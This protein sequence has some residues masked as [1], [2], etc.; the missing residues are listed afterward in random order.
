VLPL[1][2]YHCLL[3]RKQMKHCVSQENDRPIAK[4]YICEA[5]LYP[6]PLIISNIVEPLRPTTRPRSDVADSQSPSHSRT[7]T[8]P[9]RG[10]A[11]QTLLQIRNSKV[12]ATCTWCHTIPHYSP[13]RQ[14]SNDPESINKP[15]PT[16]APSSQNQ[17]T[18]SS[19]QQITKTLRRAD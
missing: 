15:R 19:Q 9:L 6:F 4:C 14:V 18:Q 5:A 11:A 10:I 16:Q 2:S 3:R 7:Q 13:F 1:T 17:Y 12:A 8:Q